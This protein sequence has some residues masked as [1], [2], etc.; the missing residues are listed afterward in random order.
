MKKAIPILVV[1]TALGVYV[2]FFHV[3]PSRVEDPTVRGSGTVE[4]TQVAISPKLPAR[5]ESI[6]VREGQQVKEG[7]LVATLACPDIRAGLA[8]AKAGVEQ[9]K[10]AVS[11]AEAAHE[12]AVA[13]SRQ[14]RVSLE[15]ID[16]AKEHAEREL[17]RAESLVKVNGIPRKAVD[18]A[19]SAVESTEKKLHA[20]RAGVG[21]SKQGVGVAKTAV[22]I[23]KANV[24]LAEKKVEQ[25]EV[26]LDECRLVSPIAGTVARRNYEP[27]EMVLPGA[28]VLEIA[29][30]PDAF[31]W[32]YVPNR[33]VGRVRLGQVVE[34]VADTYP[35]RVFRGEVVH[36]RDEAEFT[37]KSIQ[38]K[39]DRTRLVYRVKVALHNEEGALLP[40]M[41]VEAR[42][43]ETSN[44]GGAL[45]TKQSRQHAASLE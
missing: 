33:E 29:R 3:R 14:A 12:Q 4:V 32:I 21:V 34:V 20:A 40:G 5:L 39:E 30:L 18:D 15:P 43:V 27:G 19:R 7:E 23:A 44:S 41:P 24:E 42:V 9:A 28:S 26:A 10:A 25:A 31:T 2:Y 11:Q 45:E 36:I 17:A 22:A 37:P 16:V 38:T 8:A 35:D 6:V 1:L 13:A